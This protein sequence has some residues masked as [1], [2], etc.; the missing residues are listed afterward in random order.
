MELIQDPVRQEPEA[1][2]EAWISPVSDRLVA[3]DGWSQD[4]AASLLLSLGGLT[5]QGQA[6]RRLYRWFS[7]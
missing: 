7:L 3:M 4:E 5:R 6:E 2:P 1:D